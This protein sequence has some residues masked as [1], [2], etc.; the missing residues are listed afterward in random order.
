MSTEK[1]DM[2]RL[3]E[4]IT[5]GRWIVED[6]APKKLPP[7]KV[8]ISRHFVGTN[9]SLDYL[10]DST[11]DQRFWSICGATPPQAPNARQTPPTLSDAGLVKRLL[12]LTSDVSVRNLNNPCNAELVKRLLTLTPD[13]HAPILKN[14]CDE[15]EG[16]HHT[17]DL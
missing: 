5:A 3:L 7:K 9:G 12:A 11:G 1:P 13:E 10:T 4:E 17:E 14:S 2:D 8:R 16:V 15:D 6:G